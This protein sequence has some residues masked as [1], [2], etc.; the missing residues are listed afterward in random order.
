MKKIIVIENENRW[1]EAIKEAVN[2]VKQS[3][4]ALLVQN[5]G[6]KRCIR[7]EPKLFKILHQFILDGGKAYVCL[8]SLK[9]FDI[10]ET[11]PPEVFERIEDGEALIERFKKEGFEIV[12]F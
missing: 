3:E 8:K 9:K 6:V 12:K 10:P 1:E 4:T 2:N 7:C 5:D 11:R